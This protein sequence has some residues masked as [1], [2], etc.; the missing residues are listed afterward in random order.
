MPLQI[1]LLTPEEVD[2]EVVRWLRR[3]YEEATGAAAHDE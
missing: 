2:S 3:A 1:R